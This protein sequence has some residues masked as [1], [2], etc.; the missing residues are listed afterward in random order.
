MFGRPLSGPIGAARPPPL[1][2]ASP[3]SPFLAARSLLALAIIKLIYDRRSLIF[4]QSEPTLDLRQRPGTSDQPLALERIVH[5]FKTIR[6]APSGTIPKELEIGA[7]VFG[8]LTRILGD[9]DVDDPSACE[10]STP[11]LPCPM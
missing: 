7:G 8:N 5:H 6:I 3:I 9:S 1:L 10:I 11:T 2:L 4:Q